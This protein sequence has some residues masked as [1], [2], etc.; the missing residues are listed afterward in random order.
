MCIDSLRT[1]R[2]RL[3]SWILSLLLGLL[4]SLQCEAL[5]RGL[6]N[7]K[8]QL[9]SNQWRILQNNKEEK[10]KDKEKEKEKEKDNKEND[11]AA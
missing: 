9:G 4:L 2:T 8:V 7:G 11:I 3:R 1:M 5:E 10:E 6:S